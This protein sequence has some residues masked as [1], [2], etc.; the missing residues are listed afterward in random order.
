[1]HT[2]LF[3]AKFPLNVHDLIKEFQV[4]NVERNGIYRPIVSIR[5]SY[6]VQ[7]ILCTLKGCSL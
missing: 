1:M 2:L 5:E 6:T 4:L 3:K 7:S